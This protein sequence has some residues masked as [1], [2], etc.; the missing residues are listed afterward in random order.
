MLFDLIKGKRYILCELKVIK[1]I[2]VVIGG[3]IVCWLLFFII[4]V[5]SLWCVY[6]FDLFI[7]NRVL[8]YVIRIMFIF[9]LFVMNSLFNLLIYMFFNKEFCFVFSWMLCRN[10]GVLWSDVMDEVFVIEVVSVRM[11]VMRSSG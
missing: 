5:M 7:M 2:V 1:I 8:F 9:V 3:F 11:S 10:K 6:C 4:I